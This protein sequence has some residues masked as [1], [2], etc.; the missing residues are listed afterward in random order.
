M[1]KHLGA[2]A[3]V[4]ALLGC[5]RMDRGINP[6]L[7]AG[8]RNAGYGLEEL[9]ALGGRSDILIF[10]AFSG[11]G[12]RSAAFAHGALRGMRDVPVMLGGPPST[13]LEE[14]DQVAGVSGGSFTAAHYALHGRQSFE[15]FPRDFLHRDIA[16]YVWGTYLLPW[17]WG[18]LVDPGV[19]TND[20]MAEV[21]TTCCSAAPP[22]AT[23]RRAAGRGCRST[24]PTLRPARP[25][26][27]SRMPST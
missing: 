16:A 27:S 7:A 17:Q 6:P 11:G 9:N 19:G 12:K 10:V 21:T 5:G 22:S 18:W 15:T 24:R 23:C 14:I 13:L 4:L 8:A 2:L 1:S 3:L 20:R 26:R 25:F